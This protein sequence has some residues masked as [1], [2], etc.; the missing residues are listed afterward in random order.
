MSK[1]GFERNKELRKRKSF[2]WLW[3]KINTSKPAALFWRMVR[4]ASSPIASQLRQSGRMADLLE[5]ITRFLWD[6][7]G[8]TH[9]LFIGKRRPLGFPLPQNEVPVEMKHKRQVWE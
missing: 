7:S 8:I 1:D 2:G 9:A 3:F 4:L 6:E 5:K